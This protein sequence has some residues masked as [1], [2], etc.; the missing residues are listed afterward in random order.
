MYRQCEIWSEQDFV[1]TLHKKKINA[2]A[3]ATNRESCSGGE[4]N[5][6]GADIFLPGNAMLEGNKCVYRVSEN[7]QKETDAFSYWRQI[8][9]EKKILLGDK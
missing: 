4:A 6:S 8:F 5:G 2:T 1:L 3:V 9:R 7:G